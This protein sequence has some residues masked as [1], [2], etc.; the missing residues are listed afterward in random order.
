MFLDLGGLRIN[1]SYRYNVT[2]AL[3]IFFVDL[4]QD[5][6]PGARGSSLLRQEPE[7]GDLAP[8]E[9]A[10]SEGP[11][12]PLHADEAALHPPLLQHLHQVPR[13]VLS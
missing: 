2:P 1:R 3:E 12:Q 13:Y 8:A 9:E 4:W 7:R 5:S 11:A 6:L 10:V